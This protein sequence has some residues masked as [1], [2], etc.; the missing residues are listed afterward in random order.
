MGKLG[1]NSYVNKN[2]TYVD[3]TYSWGIL[4]ID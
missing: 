2:D 1:Q 3:Y 4:R